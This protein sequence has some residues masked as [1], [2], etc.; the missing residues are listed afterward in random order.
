[1][2]ALRV[3]FA[4][5]AKRASVPPGLDASGATDDV[6]KKDIDDVTEEIVEKKK[7]RIMKRLAAAARDDVADDEPEPSADGSPVYY[8]DGTIY[9][10]GSRGGYR[11]LVHRGDRN[12]KFISWLRGKPAAWSAALAAIRAAE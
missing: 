5:A 7:S 1:M 6:R 8:R 4:C 11:Y 2:P 10:S 12:T 9:T 3:V